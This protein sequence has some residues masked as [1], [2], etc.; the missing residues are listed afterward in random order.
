MNSNPFWREALDL[1]RLAIRERNADRIRRLREMGSV[2]NT[3][4]ARRLE[5][6]KRTIVRYHARIRAEDAIARKKK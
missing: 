6:S 2:P 3:E 5:V 1:G 4:A